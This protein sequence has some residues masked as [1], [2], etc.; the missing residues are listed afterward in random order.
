L[1]EKEQEKWNSIRRSQL[2]CSRDHELFYKELELSK[3][4][5]FT[6]VASFFGRSIIS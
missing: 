1:Q 6:T 4:D 5:G 2:E 3:V